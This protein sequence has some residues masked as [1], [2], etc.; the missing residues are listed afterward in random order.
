MYTGVNNLLATVNTPRF[1]SLGFPCNLFGGQEPGENNEILA[2]LQYV[3]PGNGFVPA[4]DL[5]QKVNVNGVFTDA[6]FSALRA[7]CPAP[8]TTLVEGA[9]LWSPIST[10]DIAWNFEC[11]LVG[12]DGRPYR[13][14]ATGVNP[15]DM[16]ADVQYLLNSSA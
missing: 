5:T 7:D 11:F 8:G 9:A 4:F 6:I 10:T 1:T 2:S 14:Y 13:R 12:A 15:S 3:R 16:L